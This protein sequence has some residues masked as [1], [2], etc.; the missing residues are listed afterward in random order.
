M[1]HN[2]KVFGTKYYAPNTVPTTAFGTLYHHMWV[3]GKSGVGSCLNG[4]ATVTFTR[5]N[6]RACSD[7]RIGESTRG[8]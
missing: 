5:L 6:L 7:P 8:L 1:T 2:M 4:V 3:L